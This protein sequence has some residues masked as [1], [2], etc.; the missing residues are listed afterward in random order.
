MSH[1]RIFL[2]FYTHYFSPHIKRPLKANFI[3]SKVFF[4][5]GI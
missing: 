1:V 5:L 2:F 3:F 4:L